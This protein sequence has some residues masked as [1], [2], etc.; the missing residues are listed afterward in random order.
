MTAQV[1]VLVIAGR[2]ETSYVYRERATCEVGRSDGCAIR[3]DG[4]HRSVS[5]RHCRLDIDPPRVLLRDLGSSYGTY[6]NGSRL[7]RLT[8]YQ[9]S[10]GDEIRIGDV[11]LRI[12]ASGERAQRRD[13]DHDRQDGDDDHDGYDI[14]RELGR[15]SQSVVHLARHRESGELVALKQILV[16]GT[17]D[18]S[19]RFA[20]RRELDGIRALRHPNIVQ[21]RDS[22]DR[23]DRFF[24]AYEYCPGGTLERLAALHDGR[25]PPGEALPVVHQVLS[26]LGHAHRAPLPAMRRADGTTVAARGLVHRDVKPANILLAA[27]GADGRQPVRL[28]DFGLA[29]AFEL[30]GLSGHTRTGAMGGTLP[31]TP[32]AQ[33]IDF[34]YAGPEVDVWATAA[35]LYWLLTGATPRDFPPD[36]DPVA[37][38]LREP[39]VPIRD[40]DPSV[41][42]RVARV[43]DE[44][45]V[46]TPRI[47]VRSA[48]EL[49]ATLREVG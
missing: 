5:R 41:P 8:E 49:A 20:F 31:F 26:A 3:I 17:V 4:R 33:L 24:F 13:D 14:L 11:R 10:P 1:T 6:V 25:V 21:V 32:R 39:V 27:P 35:C 16:R 23:H 46:D 29:K 2:E 7:G 36:R 19:A 9:V 42:P 30:A 45:L 18:E 28:A 22:G 15:G 48:E 40:R 37:I 38:V 12:T 44:A 34:K 43:V 47:A